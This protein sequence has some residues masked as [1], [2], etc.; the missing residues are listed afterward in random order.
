MSDQRV[1]FVGGDRDLSPQSH[2]LACAS[3]TCRRCR[4]RRRALP[5]SDLPRLDQVAGSW[6]KAIST[7]SQS[8]CG[9]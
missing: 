1:M 4:G 7:P 3:W 2:R 9:F 6:L 5:K 8:G